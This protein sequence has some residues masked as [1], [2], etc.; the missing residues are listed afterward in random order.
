MMMRLALVLVAL[1]AAAMSADV[2]TLYRNEIPSSYLETES[3]RSFVQANIDA[4]VSPRP[5]QVYYFITSLERFSSSNDTTDFRNSLRF[6]VSVRKASVYERG[7]WASSQRSSITALNLDPTQAV[8]GVGFFSTFVRDSI[9]PTPPLQC[10]FPV[11]SNRLA[12]FAVLF[13]AQ[14]PTLRYEPSVD[15]DSL[16]RS[17]YQHIADRVL[18]EAENKCLDDCDPAATRNLL[19]FW[20]IFSANPPEGIS[21]PEAYAII[22]A[23]LKNQYSY[24]SAFNPLSIAVG[25]GINSTPS[26]TYAVDQSPLYDSGSWT[27]ESRQ[28][29]AFVSLSYRLK[30]RAEKTFLSF[31]RAG[32]RILWGGTMESFSLPLARTSTF[33]RTILPGWTTTFYDTLASDGA[34]ISIRSL[35]TVMFEASAPIGY[36]TSDIS[37][38]GG[39]I[40]GMNFITY[41]G[42][43]A[44]HYK[45]VEVSTNTT[46]G[47]VDTQVI[48]S[49]EKSVFEPDVKKQQF[50]FRPQACVVYE[51]VAW[52]A[53]NALISID[54]ISFA[55]G[56]AL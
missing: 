24:G 7:R 33:D 9:A 23:L 4:L 46:D 55:L 51:P 48:T 56:Y 28:R 43:Y 1:P 12:F 2:L 39:F 47:R 36:L 8:R 53:I 21:T 6:C 30:L 42:Q 13:M 17:R 5:D 26:I 50:F 3:G 25:F 45:Q 14:D 18:R 16:R 49:G 10:P 29:Q 41:T 20:Y 32:A 22:A 27:V 40:G 37:I 44:Y 38:E 15:Y 52:L 31:V 34:R 19:E 11:D 54:Y 35:S